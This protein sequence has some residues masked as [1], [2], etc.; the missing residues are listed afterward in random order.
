MSRSDS[1]LSY[2][3]FVALRDLPT[4]ISDAI[5]DAVGAL[6]ASDV[7]AVP[8]SRTLA[9]L[10]LTAD[11]SAAAIKTALSLVKGDVGLGSVTNDAQAKASTTITAGA[12]LTGGGDLSTNRTFDVVG[13]V[14]GGQDEGS[15]VTS[16]TATTLLDSTITIPALSAGDEIVAAGS[17][18]VTNTSGSSRVHTLSFVV[19]STTVAA[20]VYSVPNLVGTVV[21][22][23]MFR[24]RCE[25]ASD[26]NGFATCSINGGSTTVA[27]GTCAENVGAGGVAFNLKGA[28]NAGGSQS[29]TLQQ[30]TLTRSRA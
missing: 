29:I 10:D 22:A 30:I 4:T 19:G 12:G 15:S 16:S 26:A 23:F 18:H 25:G 6:T 9:G 2:R 13:S 20:P 17:L 21:V 27:D 24:L 14:V 7:G 8:T 3:V 11:R 5:S 28:V 1:S